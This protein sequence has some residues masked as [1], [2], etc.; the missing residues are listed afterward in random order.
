MRLAKYRFLL[1]P[2][3]FV[4][5]CFAALAQQNSEVIG[6][7]TDPTGAAVVGAKMTLTQTETGFVYHSVSNS[8]GGYQFG[9]LNPGTYNLQV[10]A[11]GFQG[12]LQTGI[13]VIVSGTATTN[14]K[15]AVGADTQ[16]VTVTADALAV[17]TDPVKV[18][19]YKAKRHVFPRRT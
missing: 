7:V 17:Q 10:A 14:V 2:L 15:L 4:F 5:A 12:Y 19:Y 11:K 3:F 13:V 9:G 18:I 16:Q 1:V 6:T 8:T